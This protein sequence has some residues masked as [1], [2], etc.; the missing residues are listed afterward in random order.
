MKE[1]TKAILR[2][3]ILEEDSLTTHERETLLY[4]LKNGTIRFDDISAKEMLLTANA[5]AKALG[6]SPD[7]FKKIRDQAARVGVKEL[8][9]VETTPGNFMFSRLHLARFSLGE[10]DLCWRRKSP[11]VT[12][13]SYCVTADLVFPFA[14][15]AVY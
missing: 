2:T 9:G 10:Y 13:G 6:V 11:L 7:T 8:C 14:L 4:F 3:I 5:A 12:S 15:E 1:S